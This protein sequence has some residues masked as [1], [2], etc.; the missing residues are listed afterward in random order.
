MV[1]WEFGV[2]ILVG[3]VIYVLYRASVDLNEQHWPLKMGLF[4]GSV[5]LGVAAIN[6]ALMMAIDAAASEGLKATLE[7]AYWAYVTI[8]VLIMGYMI[9]SFL[10]YAF[11]MAFKPAVDIEGR[12]EA[13]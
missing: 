12:E 4:F 8:S 1:N 7:V 2:A 3:T 13:W 5:M 6:V 11:T 10:L 9:I